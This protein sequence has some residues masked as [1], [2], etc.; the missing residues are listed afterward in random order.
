M[1]FLTLSVYDVSLT[2]KKFRANLKK[3]KN[4]KHME[5]ESTF[6]GTLQR[7]S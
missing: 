4:N 7:S 6:V 5:K 3:R 1:I 2:F